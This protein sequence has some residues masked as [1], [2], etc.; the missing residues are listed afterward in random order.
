MNKSDQLLNKKSYSHD[1]QNVNCR[2]EDIATILLVYC[3]NY[4]CLLNASSWNS[5]SD[6][7]KTMLN[8]S[9]LLT[10]FFF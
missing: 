6:C 10:L 3:W 1:N 4:S 9:S 2:H 8:Y 5:Q 7:T